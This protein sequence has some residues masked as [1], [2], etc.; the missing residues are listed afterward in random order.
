LPPR[1]SL[2]H[3]LA[4]RSVKIPLRLVLV[5]P[6]VFQVVAAV[7]LTS[8]LSFRNGQTAV[9]DLAT[10]LMVEAGNR[11]DQKL[12]HTLE[13][14]VQI[15][16]MNVAEIRDGALKQQN[17]AVLGQHFA[18]QL[19]TFDGIYAIAIAD[20]RQ[21]FF[22]AERRKDGFTFIRYQDNSTNHLLTRLLVDPQ[23]NSTKLEESDDA[24][25]SLDAL[26]GISQDGAV[27]DLH[28]TWNLVISTVEENRPVFM[29]IYLQP[30]AAPVALPGLTEQGGGTLPTPKN[31]Y[32]NPAITTASEQSHGGVVA[33]SIA[34]SPLGQFLR[35]LKIGRSGRAFIIERNGLLI[36]T[37]N[38]SELPFQKH[39]V[40]SAQPNQP[41]TAIPWKQHPEYHRLSV[42][43]SQDPLLLG[44]SEYLRREFT[45]FE[46]ITQAEQLIFTADDQQRYFV[47][48]IPLKNTQS[49]DKQKQDT[50]NLDWLTVVVV[51]E[52]DFMEAIR[53]NN[54]T[55]G[56][57]MLAALAASVLVGWLTS[58]WIAEPIL[59]LSRV[60]KDLAIGKWEQPIAHSRIAEVEVLA[61][62][63]K[64]M[65]KHLHQSFDQVQT[66]RQA[67]EE[68]FTKIFRT[69]P[70]AINIV[71]LTEGR[72][73]EVNASFSAIT[74]YSRE[75]AIGR[76]A[77]ELNLLPNLSHVRNIEQLLANQ[78]E[79]RN[80]TFDLR[81]KAG[82][83]RTML[84]SAEVIDLGGQSCILSVARDITDRQQAEAKLQRTTDAL[85][86][87]QR[88]AHI[89]SWELN[90]SPEKITWSEE[91]FRIFGCD[92]A[93]PEP[94]YVEN[95]E[96]FVHPNDR[97]K[98]YHLVGQAASRGIPYET[99]LR[100]VRPDGAIR[101]V[102]A[103]G[104]P[105]FDDAG[106]V[107]RLV[108]TILDITERY[109]AEV[110]L[111]RSKQ[112][113]QKIT[114][115]LPVYIAYLDC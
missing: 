38:P 57:L 95:I 102:E 70:D 82:E 87:A 48:V 92:P 35:D 50:Q 111:Q 33:C 89:G 23:S 65:T 4:C 3:R 64:Q 62:A 109:E 115:S 27:S 97:A 86:E 72:Y 61:H 81:T 60:S 54:R 52:A 77:W 34:L 98:L 32:L 20:T 18:R 84:L 74:G 71:T 8:Y 43:N 100:L 39:I 1:K 105:V 22:A 80:Q 42:Q 36:A 104:I 56:L 51:P 31:A 9:Q 49:K 83:I 40:T 53:S 112:Q 67:S 47:R 55:T 59:R 73:V 37:S 28:S 2:T 12:A 114:D 113:L 58:E 13:L 94:G 21:N 16:T 106:Q 108:G 14:P 7:S 24:F 5:V 45:G 26:S 103:K 91:L 46:H 30:F 93:M 75:E 88:I 10:Q 96:K 44:V 41:Q 63:F 78:Q 76:T 6:F 85:Q 25:N 69:S 11:I 68:K 66:S 110:A 29:G 90:L 19:Q 107:I 15:A 79:I 17:P 99:D 101:H